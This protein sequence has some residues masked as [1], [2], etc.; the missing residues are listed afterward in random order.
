MSYLITNKQP[1]KGDIFIIP[2]Y[3]LVYVTINYD[4]YVNII[5]DNDEGNIVNS[6]SE[7]NFPKNSIYIM[8]IDSLISFLS[9]KSIN[10]FWDSVNLSDFFD[11]NNK[12]KISKNGKNAITKL[13]FNYKNEKNI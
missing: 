8:N 3:G 10:N 11:E 2:Y 5:S 13:I 12:L 4:G 7:E 9:S 1:N 6:Y